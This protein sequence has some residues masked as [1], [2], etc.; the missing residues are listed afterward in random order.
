[1]Y[2]K[3]MPFGHSLTPEIL[4]AIFKKEENTKMYS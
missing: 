2:S 4:D 3:G 1:M